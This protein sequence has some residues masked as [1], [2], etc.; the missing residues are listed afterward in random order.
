MVSARAP[1]HNG[2][3]LKEIRES[4]GTLALLA[5][6][7]FA[8]FWMGFFAGWRAAPKAAGARPEAEGPAPTVER[9]RLAEK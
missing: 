1:R 3:V 8:F 5:A 2:W 6:R 7:L 9:L 4:A